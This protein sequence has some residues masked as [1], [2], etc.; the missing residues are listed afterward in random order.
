MLENEYKFFKDNL[1]KLL[2]EY[3]GKF[4]VIKEQEIIENFPTY[5]E[6]LAFGLSQFKL[7][8]FLIQECIEE[9]KSTAQFF[10]SYFFMK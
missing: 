9:E 8:E 4:L 2:K 10:N 5:D 6:A 7:G 3:S 1:P